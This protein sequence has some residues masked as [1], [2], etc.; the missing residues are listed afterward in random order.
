[1]QTYTCTQM[2]VS[3]EMV[4]S[5]DCLQMMPNVCTPSS[6]NQEH[7][8]SYIAKVN[9]EVSLPPRLTTIPGEEGEFSVFQPAL[10]WE[11]H[12]MPLIH[13]CVHICTFISERE[14]IFIPLF[15]LVSEMLPWFVSVVG[16]V[17][18]KPKG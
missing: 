10:L 4:L 6:C 18:I 7:N 2:Y 16:F 14:A 3:P 9:A 1:M 8:C 5:F 13:A 11:T 17:A 15:T 12:R